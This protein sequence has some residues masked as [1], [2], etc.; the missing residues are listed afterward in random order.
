[1]YVSVLTHRRGFMLVTV[2]LQVRDFKIMEGVGVS[3]TCVEGGRQYRV[4]VGN[5]F[6]LEDEDDL[7]DDEG[8]Q[9]FLARHQVRPSAAA[10]ARPDDEGTG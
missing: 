10:A 3:G 2:M 4:V 1:M 9:A 5:E 6:L 7:E 8:L